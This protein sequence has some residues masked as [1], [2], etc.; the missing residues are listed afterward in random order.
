MITSDDWICVKKCVP[1]KFDW[2]IT[3]AGDGKID[4]ASC[5]MTSRGLKFSDKQITHWKPFEWVE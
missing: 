3:K 1:N 5:Y 2:V 4:F